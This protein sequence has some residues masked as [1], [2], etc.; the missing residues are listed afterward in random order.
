[1]SGKSAIRGRWPRLLL[2]A[3]P[4]G[5]RA[6]YG[7]ELEALVTDLRDNGRPAVPMAIDLLGGAAAAWLAERRIEMS[8]RSRD[9][10]VSVLWNWVAFAAVAAWFGHDLGIYPAAPVAQAL[11]VTHPVVPD[12]YHVLSAAGAVGVAVTAV[13]AVLFAVDAGRFALRSG[14]RRILLLMAVPVAVAALWIGGL[15]LIPAGGHSA[16]NLALA[17][18]WLLLGV[19]GI[20]VSTQ[21]VVSV[22]RSAEFGERTWRAGGAA[23]AAVVAAMVVAT[24]ATIIWGIAVRTSLAHP[25]DA[26]GWLVVTAV[27]AVTTGRAVLALLSTRRDPVETPAVA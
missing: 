7:D 8:E 17:T 23:A 20:A 22:L 14:R 10:L 9:A 1:M 15:R 18:G 4:P 12:A 13:A 5:W 19:A 26:T 24:G 2:A 21:A 27:M 3:Y 25:G 16:G 11:A 6:R